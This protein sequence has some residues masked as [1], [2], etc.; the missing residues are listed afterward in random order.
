MRIVSPP[1]IRNLCSLNP[2]NHPPRRWRMCQRRGNLQ[3]NLTSKTDA[4]G[5][6]ISYSYDAN[7]RLLR[8][9][10]PDTT[11]ETF[12]YDIA[13][14]MLTSTDSTGQVKRTSTNLSGHSFSNQT[15]LS[16]S[17]A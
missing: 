7:N 12:S 15:A 8:K 5:Q 4:K 2:I 9:N 11:E 1:Q 10:Y 14:R 6:T 16:I 3:H 17:F 13:G